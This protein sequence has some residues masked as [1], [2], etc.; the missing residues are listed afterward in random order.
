MLSHTPP[1]VVVSSYESAH[2]KRQRSGSISGRLRSAT[3][4]EER[5]LID[6]REK[7][8][9]KD[10]IINGGDE[11]L[12]TALDKFEG[13]DTSDLE[14]LMQHGVLSKRS[15]MDLLEDLD[16]N[17][18]Q[19]AGADA[20]GAEGAEGTSKHSFSLSLDEFGLEAP[21][22]MDGE[23]SSLASEGSIGVGLGMSGASIS[24]SMLGRTPPDPFTGSFEE[25][26]KG[27]IRGISP[28]DSS[29]LAA[30]D[31]FAAPLGGSMS[32][33]AIDIPGV[34]KD[35]TGQL[36]AMVDSGIAAE[37]CAHFLLQRQSTRGQ[38]HLSGQPQAGAAP[39]AA[40]QPPQQ[41]PHTQNTIQQNPTHPHPQAQQPLPPQQQSIQPLR[42]GVPPGVAPGAAPLG[43][44]ATGILGAA[45]TAATAVGGT[46]MEATDRKHYI[47]AYSPEAR[48]KR[49]QRFLE[50]RKKR[51][52]TKKV[53]YDV[54][55]NFADSRMRVKGRFVKKEDEEL[56]RELMSIT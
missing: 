51:V 14:V 25:H 12:Q 34:A 40:D 5:G 39:L 3:A 2:K 13:G 11:R 48:R 56:L 35:R 1:S 36:A 20:P 46:G 50:K 24:P 19:V 18:L 38:P 47:G 26:A 45:A 15:S 44:Q 41:P 8:V 55:K 9:L 52:W 30:L 16:M 37:R 10:L 28:K 21:F 29:P 23:G 6:G 17:F 7:G 32:S 42:P 49:I 22:D 31:A 43:M 53:K 33:S 4:L 54:R 27:L